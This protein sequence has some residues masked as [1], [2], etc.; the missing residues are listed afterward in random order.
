MET[1]T[2]HSSPQVLPQVLSRPNIDT[3][4]ELVSLTYLTPW[5]ISPKLSNPQTR[6]RKKMKVENIILPSNKNNKTEKKTQ[7]LTQELNSLSLQN[8]QVKTPET[9][10]LPSSFLWSQEEALECSNIFVPPL[11]SERP[12]T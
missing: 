11:P 4:Y 1:T 8:D 7:V 2:L 10:K 6:N 12:S 9:A 3:Q 5:R